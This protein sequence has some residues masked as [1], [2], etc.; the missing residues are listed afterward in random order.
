[1]PL[2]S[3]ARALVPRLCVCCGSAGAEDAVCRRCSQMLDAQIRSAAALR[4]PVP[5]GL[6]AVYP[7]APH[8]GVARRLLAALKFRRLTSAATEIAA[9]IA[10]VLPDPGRHLVVPVPPASLR[11]LARGFDP[12]GEIARAL[13]LEIGAAR[14][15]AAL[16]RR[17][18]GRQARGSRRERLADPPR[19]ECAGGAPGRILLV[20]DVLTTGATLSACA[21]ALRRAGATEVV[22]T[23]FT[24]E[25]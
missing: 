19:I 2:S 23:T 14:P 5:A 12:A 20:D 15:P 24:R 3:I 1:M 22:G 8:E 7:A 11:L 6:D 13:Q 9:R 4:D 25:V 17:D 10:P 18:R 16:R 21:R